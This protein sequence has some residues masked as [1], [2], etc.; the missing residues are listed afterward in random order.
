MPRNRSERSVSGDPVLD[1]YLRAFL[2]LHNFSWSANN[3]TER[4]SL[5]RRH[6]TLLEALTDKQRSAIAALGT[7]GY[8]HLEQTR[9]LFQHEPEFQHGTQPQ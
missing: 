2:R 6:G 9:E 7:N 3:G 8:L 1:E 5:Q 4:A